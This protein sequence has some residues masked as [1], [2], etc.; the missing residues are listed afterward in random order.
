M[1]A[2]IAER[3]STVQGSRLGFL[4]DGG[5]RLAAPVR[6]AFCH[7]PVLTWSHCH[8]LTILNTN[9]PHYVH[10]IIH[11]YKHIDTSRHVILY[12]P[13]PMTGHHMIS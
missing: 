6:V 7:D 9:F 4:D 2:N 11:S 5:A 8:D 3:S 1:A 12:L 13:Y 10:L